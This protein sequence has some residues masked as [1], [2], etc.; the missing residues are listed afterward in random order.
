MGRVGLRAQFLVGSA[1]LP[2]VMFHTC[3]EGDARSVISGEADDGPRGMLWPY[4]DGGAPSWQAQLLM[5]VGRLG[6]LMGLGG[7]EQFT[8]KPHLNGR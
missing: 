1:W 6:E 7:W 5:S 3:T 8:G 2:P 4:R